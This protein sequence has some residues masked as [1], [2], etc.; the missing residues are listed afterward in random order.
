M[1]RISNYKQMK[2]KSTME[3]ETTEGYWKIVKV[4]C[5]REKGTSEG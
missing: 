1:R 5:E 2:N 3:N 4:S